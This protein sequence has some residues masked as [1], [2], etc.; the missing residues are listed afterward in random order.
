MALEI[1]FLNTFFGEWLR[2]MKIPSCQ[3]KYMSLTENIFIKC[4]TPIIIN[5]ATAKSVL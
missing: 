5:T 1:T 4:N 2:Y 3:L